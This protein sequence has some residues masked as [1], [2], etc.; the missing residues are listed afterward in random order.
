MKKS[1]QQLYNERILRVLI[2][3]QKNLDAEMP[4]NELARAAHF[5]PYHFHR[6]FRGMVG[7]SLKEHIRRLRLERA[8]LRLK[9][10]DRSVLEI[11]LEAGYETHEAFSRAFRSLCGCSPSGFRSDN[12]RICG[13][14][15][16]GVHYRENGS[17]AEFEL[18]TGGKTM[19]VRVEHLEPMR[20]AFVRHV[21][22][23]SQV[24][25]A[26]EK[27]CA[28]LGREGLLAGGTR[29]V[30]VCYDDPEVTAPEKLRYDACVTVDE[31]FEAEG[32]VGVQTICGGE[33]AVVTHFG[34]YEDL[35]RTYGQL[36]GRWMP[37]N[38]RQPRSEPC[39][40]FY[41]N[42][43]DGTDPEDLLTDIYAPLEPV[44]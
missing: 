13:A 21:G 29:F 18:T 34:P 22:P 33:Y 1:T 39:L 15:A 23:Y 4:L 41:L 6:I 42:D 16:P 24:G 3:I 17:M 28:R 2:L 8:A 37:Q 38:G 31:D 7:E 20:V 35:G 11:A 43:P 36:Y 14:N 9:H 10:T 40:E 12:S 30:G 44:S 26:W 25:K 32:E 27:L 19:D 5:S